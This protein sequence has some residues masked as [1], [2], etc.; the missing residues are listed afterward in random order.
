MDSP[1]LYHFH[2]LD[3]LPFTGNSSEYSS[4]VYQNQEC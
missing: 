2:E 3:P 4:T 1:Y